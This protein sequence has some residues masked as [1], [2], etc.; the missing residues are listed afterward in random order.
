MSPFAEEGLPPWDFRLKHVLPLGLFWG[1]KLVDLWMKL[2]KPWWIMVMRNFWK[3]KREL[4]S[5]H[6]LYGE[7]CG[8][9]YI[10]TLTMENY[11]VYVTLCLL[12][13]FFFGARLG[14]LNFTFTSWDPSWMV[15][16]W[17]V[18]RVFLSFGT[19]NEQVDQGFLQFFLRHRSVETSI[20]HTPNQDH[21]RCRGLEDNFA[22]KGKGDFHGLCYFFGEW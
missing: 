19:S 16:I 22:R 1:P 10:M 7:L 4:H 18:W 13:A 2:M 20:Y 21:A 6:K 8:L 5:D 11:M 15:G 12:F 14:W 3:L 9:S 17:R